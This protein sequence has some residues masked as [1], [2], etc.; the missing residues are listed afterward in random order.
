ML[1]K[2]ALAWARRVMFS[3][4]P[5]FEIGGV[6]G[7]RYLL[8]WFVTPWSRFDRGKRDATV[9]ERI[10]ES[11]P[12]VY[13]HQ[14]IR[15]DDDRALH[16]HPWPSLTWILENDYHEVL[17]LPLPYRKVEQYRAAGWDRPTLSVFRPEGWIGTRGAETAHRVV[18]EK[19][20][21]RLGRTEPIPATTLFIT[22]FKVREWGFWCPRGWIDRSR[23]LHPDDKGSTGNGCGG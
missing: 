8:R 4:P 13:V 15:D 17:F 10:K 7:D 11:L 16:D 18:L 2:F 12:N 22:G 21:G 9:W 20:A 14:F 5:D 23:F 1:R 19:R 3:R 6:P